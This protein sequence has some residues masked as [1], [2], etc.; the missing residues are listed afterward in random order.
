MAP[1]INAEAVRYLELLGLPPPPP[2]PSDP[3]LAGTVLTEWWAQVLQLAANWGDPAD[4]E[5]VAREQAERELKAADAAAKF[6]ANE[7]ASARQLAA[8]DPGGQGD[9]FAQQIPQLISGLV[10]GLTGGLGGLVAPLSQLPAQ[11]GQLGQQL[12][13]QL[14]SAAG[15]AEPPVE[16]WLDDPLGDEFLSG[17]DGF[18]S[19]GSGGAGPGGADAPGSGPTTPATLL[20][21]PPAPSG[22]TVPTSGRSVPVVPALP[23]PHAAPIAPGVGGMPMMPAAPLAGAPAGGGGAEPTGTRRVSVPTVRNGAPVQGRIDAPP[24]APAVTKRVEGRVT[25]TRRIIVEPRGGDRAD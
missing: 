20:G 5:R 21:P 22:A 14:S 25:A 24:A 16:D 18:G 10:G 15:Q 17:A 8:V 11:A 2:I 12:A 13:E 6:P 7:E 4:A 19:D 3:V 1:T 9:Q 23:A